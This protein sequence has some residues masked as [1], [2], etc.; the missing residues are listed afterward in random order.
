MDYEVAF[1]QQAFLHYHLIDEHITNTLPQQ[2]D[3]FNKLLSHAVR[4]NKDPT[5]LEMAVKGWTLHHP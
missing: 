1:S 5:S 3:E 2:R 4:K